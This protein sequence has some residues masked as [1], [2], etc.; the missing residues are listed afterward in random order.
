MW[1][2]NS[3]SGKCDR[4]IILM[5]TG[6]KF[7][8]FCDAELASQVVKLARLGTDLNITLFLLIYA[9]ASKTK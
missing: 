3:N 5:T 9:S 4:L 2:T 7:Q 6:K 8:V 1:H